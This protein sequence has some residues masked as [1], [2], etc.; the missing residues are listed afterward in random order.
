MEMIIVTV[1]FIR[2]GIDFETVSNIPRISA[3]LGVAVAREVIKI[4][5]LRI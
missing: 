2:V 3:F 1:N 5:L 4:V